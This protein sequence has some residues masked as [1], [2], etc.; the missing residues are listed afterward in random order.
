MEALF[1]VYYVIYSL[2][3]LSFVISFSYQKWEN[4]IK[5]SLKKAPI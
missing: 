4:L 5:L 1:L 2:L 3:P